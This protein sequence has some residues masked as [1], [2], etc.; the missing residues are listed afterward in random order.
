MAGIIVPVH[1]I[2]WLENRAADFGIVVLFHLCLA[3]CLADCRLF[4]FFF[5]KI[6]IDFQSF[7]ILHHVYFRYPQGRHANFCWNYC[8]RYVC[9]N[10]V[11][12]LFDLIMVRCA[13]K[14]CGISSIQSLLLSSSRAFIPSPKLLFALSTKPLACG[15]LTKAKRWRMHIF[16]HQSLNGHPSRTFSRCSVMCRGTPVMSA[17]FQANMSRLRLSCVSGPETIVHSS[18]IIL[19]LHNV[20]IPP[21]SGNFNI[22]WAVDETAWILLTLGRP[23]IP[24]YGDGDLT[25][26]K[27]IHAEVECSASL[28]FTSSDICPTGHMISVLKP[29]RGAVTGTI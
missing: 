18:G 15:C 27:F 7:I 12:P 22:P 17:G 20:S 25:T 8:F 3:F 29:I 6:Q 11:S 2:S 13:H 4:S 9:E 21:G 28:I 26:T 23:M 5:Q 14:T 10:G 19:L 1:K 16:S 24:L